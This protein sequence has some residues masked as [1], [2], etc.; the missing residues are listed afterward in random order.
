M[1]FNKNMMDILEILS[2]TIPSLVTGGVAYYFFNSFLQFNAKEKEL[3]LLAD[4]KKESLPLKL[5]AYERMLLFCDRINPVKLLVR[6]KPIDDD[7]N[8]YLQLLIR[9]I[10]QELEHNFVQQIYLSDTAWNAILAAKNA[11]IHQLKQLAEETDDAQ[12]LR[13]NALLKY[14]KALP[15][16]DTAITILKN[17]VRKLL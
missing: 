11:V 5:Q 16:T 7:T 15:P 6:I 14:T 8:R 17:E 4:R 1:D 10:E 2:Y 12:T 13:E 3:A 9:N